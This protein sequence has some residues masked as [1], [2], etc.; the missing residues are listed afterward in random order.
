MLSSKISTADLNATSNS[1]HFSVD[2]KYGEEDDLPTWNLSTTDDEENDE[3]EYPI[4]TNK[5]TPSAS[6]QTKT[7][8]PSPI[9]AVLIVTT[10]SP[11][12]TGA[13]LSAG[14]SS[15]YVPIKPSPID[16]KIYL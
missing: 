3:T 10:N 1:E 9:D 15:N 6:A 7:D 14:L 4:E 2:T 11:V 8:I 5:P 16:E 13:K 12:F